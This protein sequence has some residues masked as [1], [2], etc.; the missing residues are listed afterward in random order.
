MEL[1]QLPL[2]PLQ[3]NCYLL[4]NKEKE[5]IVFDPGGEGKRLIDYISQEGLK[6]LAILLTHAHFDHIGAVEE[7]RNHW[8][9]PVYIHEQEK[10]WLVEPGLNGSARYPME[11]ISGKPADHLFTKEEKI[12]IGPFELELLETPGHSPGSLSYYIR[13]MNSVLSGDALFHY[14]I[15]RTDLPGGDYSTLIR[16]IHEKLFALPD[17]TA[18]FPGHGTRTTIGEEKANN[19]Y[20]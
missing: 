15:G 4:F 2:G 17:E 20:V 9:I 10:D 14:G 6:P 11:P 5:C 19:P 7:A 3:A 12:E 1:K 13:E 8:G 16:S 18:V